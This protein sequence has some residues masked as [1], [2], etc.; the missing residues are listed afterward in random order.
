MMD[1]FSI[2]DGRIDH[3]LIELK[4]INKFLGGNATSQTGFREMIK[5][6]P[7][8]SFIKI[9]DAGSGASDIVLSIKKIYPSLHIFS[10]DLNRRTCFYAKKNSL[11]IKIVCGNVLTIPFKKS[12]FD[13]A[14]ASLFFHHF[15][16]EEIKII[17]SKLLDAVNYGIIINDLKRSF[18]AY[19]GIKFLTFLFSQSNM[20]KNDAPLSVKRGFIKSE[21]IKI[22]GDLEIKN[23][24]IKRTHVFRWLILIYKY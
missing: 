13:F 10:L 17:I 8:N 9:L 20:V 16:E 2:N 23:Y 18:I 4:I 7:K 14:H 3:A 22:L 12:S 5:N 21:L 1:D 11:N 24:R 19:W 6:V 15:K